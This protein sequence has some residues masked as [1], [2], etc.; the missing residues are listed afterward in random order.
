[1]SSGSPAS[2]RPPSE[3]HINQL[4]PC[5]AASGWLGL[6]P[7]KLAIHDFEANEGRRHVFGNDDR[8]RDAFAGRL[9]EWVDGIRGGDYR[10]VEDRSICPDYDFRRFCRYAAAEAKV[11]R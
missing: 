3:I 5:A 4:R 1:M 2:R 7:A 9:E 11:A 10:P 6:K 8:E